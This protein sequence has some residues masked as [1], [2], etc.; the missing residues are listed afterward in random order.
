MSDG[1]RADIIKCRPFQPSIRDH[2]DYMSYLWVK[3]L[4]G[5]FVLRQHFV[6]GQAGEWRVILEVEEDRDDFD[7][8][9]KAGDEIA[10]RFE[11]LD[12]GGG[13]DPAS[14]CEP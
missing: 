14:P 4:Q 1:R 2:A 13:Q 5:C 12:A 3:S 7:F 6:E 10:R 9:D 8:F 11:E